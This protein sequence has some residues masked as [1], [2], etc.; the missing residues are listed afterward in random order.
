MGLVKDHT[1]RCAV[2]IRF[3]YHRN[4]LVGIQ[5]PG[6]GDGVGKD[7]DSLVGACRV[8]GRLFE[9]LAVFI[10]EGDGLIRNLDAGIGIDG[11]RV[12]SLCHR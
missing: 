5:G 4:K 1:A 8:V 3:L 7:I 2:S 10:E 12:V 9:P 11:Q 6:L